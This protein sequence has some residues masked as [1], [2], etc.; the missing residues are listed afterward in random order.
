M[1]HKPDSPVAPTTLGSLR[2]SP[3]CQFT[4]TAVEATLRLFHGWPVCSFPVSRAPS[5][6]RDSDITS[7]TEAI[8]RAQVCPLQVQGR[9]ATR[10]STWVTR[11]AFG[12]HCSSKPLEHRPSPGNSDSRIYSPLL[13]SLLAVSRQAFNPAS[14]GYNTSQVI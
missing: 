5:S 2:S 12:E 10:M 14:K 7:T 11:S 6:S 13:P 3:H 1:L 8:W 9:P 4:D